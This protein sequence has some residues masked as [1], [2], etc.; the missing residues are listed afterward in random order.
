[1]K[2]LFLILLAA[3]TLLTLVACGDEHE[4]ATDWE[5][6][7]TEHWHACTV[8]GCTDTDAKAA[9]TFETKGVTKAA[10]GT[11]AGEETFMCSVCGY[12]KT[13]P[14]AAITQEA[15]TALFA[16]ENVKING[17]ADDSPAEFL[18]SGNLVQLTSAGQTNYVSREMAV[19][20]VDFSTKLADFSTEDGKTYKAASSKVALGDVE[21]V[22][23][24][25]ADGKL[26]SVKY[27]AKTDDDGGNA[28]TFTFSE[29][30]KVTVTAPNL[31]AEQWANALSSTTLNNYSLDMVTKPAE[32][33]WTFEWFQFNGSS[34][35]HWT[36]PTT[37][38]TAPTTGESGTMENAGTNM[39]PGMAALM[40][41]DVSKFAVDSTAGAEYGWDEAAIYSYTESVSSFAFERATT[42]LILCLT[43]EDQIAKMVVVLSDG[44]ELSYEF[45]TYG[46][47]TPG[48]PNYGTGQNPSLDA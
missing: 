40:G 1:M 41:L 32:G 22:E 23:I 35:Y 13:E 43:S 38:Q 8:E 46:D 16:L 18:I 3:I 5:K 33:E 28:L 44:T 15:W 7:A 21:N 30:G 20:Y 25:L 14:F 48:S 42:K 47:T 11:T 4:F 36:N 24:V 39:V 27:S 9:H 45:H 19:G 37:N 17:L 2:K 12:A 6:N 34:Y 29:W 10:V 31:T 26:A